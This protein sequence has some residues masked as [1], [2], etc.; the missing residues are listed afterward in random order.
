MIVNK[1][2]VILVQ[3]RLRIANVVR[4][5]GMSKFTLL[6]YIITNHLGLTLKQLTSCVSFWK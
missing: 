4:A 2:P 3:K 1:F 6:N 5:T